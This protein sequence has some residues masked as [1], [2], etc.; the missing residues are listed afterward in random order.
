[1]DRDTL[2]G[3][4]KQFERRRAGA[5]GDLTDDDFDCIAGQREQFVGRVQERYGQTREAAEREV[6]DFVTNLREPVYR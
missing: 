2:A 4:W 6:D 1:M 3:N 5:L